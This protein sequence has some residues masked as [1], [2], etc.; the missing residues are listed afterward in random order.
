MR[1]RR[2]SA[3]VERFVRDV[4]VGFPHEGDEASRFRIV[5]STSEQY[6]K[7]TSLWN[8]TEKER[9]REKNE[10]A[11]Y[12]LPIQLWVRSIV[13]PIG[14]VLLFSPPIFFPVT[15]TLQYSRREVQKRG[16]IMDELEG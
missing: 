3:Y 6:L 2:V 4:M 14:C 11:S 8:V 16:R 15:S 13:H 10:T 12:L 5:S 9:E 1:W 7:G